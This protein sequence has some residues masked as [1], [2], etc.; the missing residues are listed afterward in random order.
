MVL[1]IMKVLVTG[2]VGFI[3]SNLIYRLIKDGHIVCSL[4]NYSTGKYENEMNGCTYYRYDL[5]DISMIMDRDFDVIFHLA[6]LARIQPSFSH[7]SETFKS[8]VVGTEAVLEFARTIGA[9]VI[10]AGSSSR[11][12]DP[13]KSP[14]A[15][16]K[17][18]GEELCKMYRQSL[19]CKIQIA[20]FYNVY[21]PGEIMDGDY[22]TVIGIW[23]RQIMDGEPITIV[24]DGEQR[25]DFTHVYDIVDGLVRIMNTEH[26]HDDAWELG[27]GVNYS[28]NELYDMFAER[29]GSLCGRSNTPDLPGN[30]RITFREHD[31]ALEKLGW[32]PVDRLRTY[33]S[34]L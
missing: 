34:E 21:G 17:Y 11:W 4:D 16:S 14:Y 30:Y 18:L 29:F 13:R 7:P 32:K 2:G 20:R 8:N 33:I 9:K 28:I 24:G 19:G 25:R 3:G 6:A 1:Y 23:R 5:T 26:Y 27:T 10:Y 12:H 31:D 22:A 15:M